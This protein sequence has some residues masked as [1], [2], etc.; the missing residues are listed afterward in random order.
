[1]AYGARLESVLG[2]TPR[3]F[4]S[5]ILRHSPSKSSGRDVTIAL[6]AVA[7]GAAAQAT[8]GLG[9]ALV[10][11]PLLIA[12]LGQDQGVRTVV[13]LSALLNAAI[14]IRE[15]RAIRYADGARV[16]LPAALA[17]PLLVPLVQR[18]DRDAAAIV[19]GVLTVTASMLVLAGARAG[20]LRGRAGAAAAGLI[21]AAMNAIAGIGGPPVA[22]YA[23]NAGW[24]A[25]AAR[26]T[27]QAIFLVL[28]SVLL[29]RIGLPAFSPWLLVAMAFGYAAGVSATRSLSEQTAR[30]A[31][32]LI[33]GAGGLALVRT[34]W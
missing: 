14:L 24:S 30:R 15:H 20:A 10:S 6:F 22:L 21:S 19:A 11:G 4:E 28:N 34:I 33:A 17:T 26:A 9:F 32:L 3:E 1:M 16:L 25:A 5:R 7:L 8:S 12:S 18:L 29:W 23:A 2:A 27:M 31:T 13:L